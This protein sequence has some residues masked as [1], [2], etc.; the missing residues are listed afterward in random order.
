MV[1]HRFSCPLC[2]GAASEPH[3][4]TRSDGTSDSG[5]LRCIACRRYVVSTRPSEPF[6]PKY[7]KPY[8]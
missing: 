3:V 1:Q 7:A 8:R 5:W 4:M 2:G 6:V